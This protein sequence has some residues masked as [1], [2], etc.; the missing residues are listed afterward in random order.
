MRVA[1][2]LLGAFFVAATALLLVSAAS[3]AW[4]GT[5]LDAIWAIAPD[6]LT[7]L[8]PHRL[9]VAAGFAFLAAVMAVAAVGVF[10][11]R[12]WARKLAI[13]IFVVNG[14]GDAVDALTGQPTALIGVAV[15]GLVV[16]WLLQSAVRREFDAPA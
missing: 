12:E 11:R 6:K 1:R 14:A 10:R 13:A 3:L 16:F 7:V 15:S 8:A 2:L 4:P 5:C 9:L